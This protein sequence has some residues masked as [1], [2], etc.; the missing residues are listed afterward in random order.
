MVAT[1][2]LLSTSVFRRAEDGAG[3]TFFARL[4]LPR[5]TVNNVLGLHI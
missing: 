4:T 2:L 3:T 1:A 5:A